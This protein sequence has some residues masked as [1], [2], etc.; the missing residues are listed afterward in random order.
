MAIMGIVAMKAM[1]PALPIILEM[2]PAAEA[3]ARY[4]NEVQRKF[5]RQVDQIGSP[6]FSAEFVAIRIEL[7]AYCTMAI[8]HNITTKSAELIPLAVSGCLNESFRAVKVR[9]VE[10]AITAELKKCVLIFLLIRSEE[11]RASAV[12]TITAAS[13]P[14]SK[15]VRK[16]KVSET[17]M[18]ACTRGIWIVT[19]DPTT[20]VT[21]ASSKKRKSSSLNGNESAQKAAVA[22]PPR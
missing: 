12:A 8:K 17:E 20:I 9:K 7:L 22:P 4:V 19:R 10:T 21:T 15:S 18:W 5:L 1:N 3:P 14:N 16:I 13:P 2:K 6:A 11:K